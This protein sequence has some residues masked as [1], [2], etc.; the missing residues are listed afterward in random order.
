M[1]LSELI[2][3]SHNNITTNET[4]INEKV[5]SG[6]QL[7]QVYTKSF[8]F[9]DLPE[10][11]NKVYNLNIPDAE[12][13]WLDTANSYIHSPSVVYYPTIYSSPYVDPTNVRNSISYSINNSDKTIMI[14]TGTTGWSL[15]RAFMVVRYYK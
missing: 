14:K 6:N 4:K 7:K 9:S 8:E 13:V 3:D 10:N 15:Y 5:L 12:Y 11:G 2:G 1:L